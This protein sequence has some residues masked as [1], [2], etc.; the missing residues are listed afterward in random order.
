MNRLDAF[1][2]LRG[3]GSPVFRTS[4][5]ARALGQLDSTTHETLS[6]L[7]ER[8]LITPIRRG[9]W[10]LTYGGTQDVGALVPHLAAPFRAYISFESALFRHGWITQI[11][12][13]VTVATL[14]R[15]RRVRT[16]LGTFDLRQLPP[17]VFDPGESA[18]PPWLARPE[19]AA[20]DWAYRASHAGFE[21][22]R[23][24][25]IEPTD[26]PDQDALVSHVS[27]IPSER[28]RTLTA[29]ILAERMH[30]LR[31]AAAVR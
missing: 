19:K 18:N 24:P 6:V 9:W 21:S 26:K 14:G 28:V 3:M 15:S 20:V 22:A 7:A 16:R 30:L 11:P 5:A 13:R 8:G 4:E 12:P 31:D 27:R 23:F 29:R 25:E 10:A 1:E 2:Q 17:E